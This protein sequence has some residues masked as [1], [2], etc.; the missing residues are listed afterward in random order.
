M[1]MREAKFLSLCRRFGEVQM[2]HCPC[3]SEGPRILIRKS[4]TASAKCGISAGS[5]FISVRVLPMRDFCHSE[6]NQS[7][8]RG[9]IRGRNSKLHRASVALSQALRFCCAK[10]SRTG[11]TWP[12]A[13]SASSGATSASISLMQSVTPALSDSDVGISLVDSAIR[14]RDFALVERHGDFVGGGD[15]KRSG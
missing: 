6:R 4:D 11:A 15:S 12:R 7:P 2:A 9:V 5:D 8:A 13:G 10:M 3:S 14:S 1:Q